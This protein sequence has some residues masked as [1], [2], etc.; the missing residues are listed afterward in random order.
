MTKAWY[1]GD[2]SLVRRLPSF[3]IW[4]TTLW[5]QNYQKAVLGLPQ[6]GNPTIIR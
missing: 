5:S 4:A 3:G 6:I 2:Q 1:E